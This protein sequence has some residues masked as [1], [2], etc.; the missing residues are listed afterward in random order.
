MVSA[1]STGRDRN[2]PD[3]RPRFAD[4][5]PR[6]IVVGAGMSGI[7]VAAKLK[8]AGISGFTVLEKASDV[9]GTWRDN[10]YPGLHCDV[11]SVFYQY[12]F[13]HNPG[14][15]HWLSPGAE[16]QDYFGAAVDHYG[17]RD[18]IELGTEA[19]RGEFVNGVWR[20]HDR[21]GT[22]READFLIAATGVLH[23]PVR[24]D[25]AGLD[26]FAGAMFHSARWD[27]TVPLGDKRVA[28]IGTGSTGAQLV[29]ALAGRVAHL[30]VFQRTA[31]WI[32]PTPN[33]PTDPVTKWLRAKVSWWMGAECA[34]IKAAFSLFA[35]ALITPG[36]QRWLVDTL[37]RVHLCT[38]RNPELRRKLTPAYQPGCKRL[39]MSGG[40]YRAVQRRNVEV[41]T[42][43]ID[44][45]EARGIVTAD[46]QLHQADV[47]VLATGFDSHAY[48]RPMELVG[49]DARTLA[50]AW[51]NGPHAY[52]TVAL[53]GFPNF[54]MLMGPHSPIG[55]YSLVAIAETQ[56]D[57][58]LQ[59]IRAWQQQRF[60]VAAPT[61]QATADYN[62]G[63]RRA[64]PGTVWA[65][66][67]ASWYLGKDGTPEV[68][69]WT[70]ERHARM[71][72]ELHVDEF[73][74]DTDLVDLVG[75]VDAGQAGQEG[76]RRCS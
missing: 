54:F 59:W 28:L 47:V 50:Q 48:L 41:V 38:V 72:A 11:P 57:H 62:A 44:H 2:A 56:S 10:R 45:V 22:V 3:R 32:L 35:R 71:L 40:F 26:D 33:W 65:S 61:A 20:V 23:H 76:T 53:P 51:R 55:N 63:L 15:S 43:P 34:L 9:G 30:D 66:G 24:P 42:T 52:R 27:D 18:H 68:W 4:R 60:D 25:I 1:A 14:W 49:P 73:H 7:C 75:G 70:P 64:L 16:I 46:G 36:W 37:C 17:L 5:Q 39:V 8:L 19:T 13:H 69:P 29:T 74:L 21:A 12:S 58:I 67:C 6:V 31:Q